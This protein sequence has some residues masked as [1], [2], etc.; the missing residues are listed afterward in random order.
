MVE[1][2]SDVQARAPTDKY[3]YVLEEFPKTLADHAD[4]DNFY[5]TIDTD[6]LDNVLERA[7]EHF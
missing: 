5:F 6:S 2:P 7:S 1:S 4:H 3:Q